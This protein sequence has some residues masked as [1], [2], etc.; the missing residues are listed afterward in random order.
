MLRLST[1]LQWKYEAGYR[2]VVLDEYKKSM[3]FLK[4]DEVG[5]WLQEDY[6]KYRE[7][8]ICGKPVGF[9]DY[10]KKHKPEKIEGFL[11][12]NTVKM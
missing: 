10:V 3:V 12:K 7:S 2:Y 9:M 11:R 8:L 5:C 6:R 1:L 4:E